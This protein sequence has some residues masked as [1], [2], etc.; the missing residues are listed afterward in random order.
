MISRAWTRS[1]TPASIAAIVT[2]SLDTRSPQLRAVAFAGGPPVLEPRQVQFQRTFPGAEH[3]RALAAQDPADKATA[4]P[5]A[6]HDLL[7][8]DPVLRQA[9]DGPVCLFPTKIAL[10]LQPLGGREQI[11]V[12]GRGT[13]RGPDLTHGFAH[14]VEKGTAGVLHQ[15]PAVSHLRG[16]RQRLGRSRGISAAA[17]TSDGG[18]LGL[19]GQLRLRCRGLP[20]R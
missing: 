6:A 12:D 20:V 1:G 16:L 18:D 2:V 15:V 3:V 4:M 5:G 7:N 14:R 19:A 10:I 13:D 11:R 8:R 17:I 9:K